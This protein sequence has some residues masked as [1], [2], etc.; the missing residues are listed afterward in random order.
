VHGSPMILDNVI[1][2]NRSHGRWLRFFWESVIII[3]SERQGTE[4]GHQ[5]LDASSGMFQVSAA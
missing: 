2:E 1:R 4:T 5:I 3:L